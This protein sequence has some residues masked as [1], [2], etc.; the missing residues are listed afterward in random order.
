MRTHS[1]EKII[2]A[3]GGAAAFARLLGISGRRGHVQRV[4]NWKRRGIPARVLLEHG[5]VIAALVNSQESA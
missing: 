4:S 3:A 5:S 2:N 1:A